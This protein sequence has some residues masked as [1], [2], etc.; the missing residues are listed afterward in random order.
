MLDIA[1]VRTPVA[2]STFALTNRAFKV[3]DRMYL[4]DHDD[5]IPFWKVGLKKQDFERWINGISLMIGIRL[6][7]IVYERAKRTYY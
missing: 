1:G 6:I 3:R 5:P 7:S 4:G 2:D